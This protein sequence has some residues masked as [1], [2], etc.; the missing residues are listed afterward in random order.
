MRAQ[1]KKASLYFKFPNS[2]VYRT[3][4]FPTY[5]KRKLSCVRPSSLPEYVSQKKVTM[6]FMVDQEFYFMSTNIHIDGDTITFNTDVD[7]QHLVRR[8]MKRIKLPADAGASLFIKKLN[9]ELSFI[10]TVLIDVSIQ[11]CRAGFNL[12]L[13]LI[14]TNDVIE[15]FLRFGQYQS[16]NLNAKVLSQRVSF[17]GG[18]KQ[19]FGLKFSEFSTYNMNRL[20]T[21]LLLMQTNPVIKSLQR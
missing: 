10:K 21:I 14:S 7:V 18:Y 16:L 3:Q 9:G 8:R 11:G 6:S 5:S 13:P 12:E 2:M 19:I 1:E 20:K 15:G 4:L 17:R